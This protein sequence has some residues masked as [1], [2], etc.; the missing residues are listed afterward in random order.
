[1]KEKLKNVLKSF[2]LFLAFCYPLVFV[3]HESANLMNEFLIQ[4]LVYDIVLVILAFTFITLYKSAKSKSI[5]R[6]VFGTFL[7]IILVAFLTIG[8]LSFESRFGKIYNII[9]FVAILV[10]W[11]FSS[12]E[13]ENSVTLQSV[14]GEY[15]SPKW[16]VDFKKSISAVCKN[17]SKTIKKI[18]IALASCVV[19]VFVGIKVYAFIQSKRPVNFEVTATCSGVD[20]ENDL[21][22]TLRISFDQSACEL[23]QIEQETDKVEIKPEIKG[24]WRWESESSLYFYPSEAW[25][26]GT[27]YSI[28]L[29]KELVASHITLTEKSF[30]FKTSEF[31]ARINNLE[32]VIDDV[33][34]DLKYVVCEVNANFPFDTTSFDGKVKFQPAMLNSKNGFVENRDYS[35]TVTFSENKKTAYIRSEKIGIPATDVTMKVIVLSGVKSTVESKAL[36]EISSSIS[37]DG[38]NKFA[39]I[40]N[41]EVFIAQDENGDGTQILNFNLAGKVKTEDLAKNLKVYLLPKDRPE[42]PGT[43]GIENYD[44]SEGTVSSLVLKK[45]TRLNLERIF[46]ETEYSDVQNFKIDVPENSYI[47]IQIAKGVKFYGG[48]TLQNDYS[49]LVR[50]PPFEKKLEIV[51]KGSLLSLRGD[52]KLS[53]QTRGVK[54]LCFKIWRLKPDEINDIVTQSN[55]RFENFNFE[56]SRFDERNVGELYKEEKTIT[57]SNGFSAK[58]ATFTSF[59]F[60]KYLDTIA[61]NGIKNG[62][63]LLTAYDK[64][65]TDEVGYYDEDYVYR[66]RR[67]CSD[68]RLILVSDL[69]LIVKKTDKSQNIFVQSVKSGNPVSN[70]LV[71]LIAKNGDVLQEARTNETGYVQFQNFRNRYDDDNALNP[72]VYTVS[73][74]DDFSFMPYDSSE[75]R[76]DYSD[77][78]VSGNYDAPS[79]NVISSYIFSDRGIY[80]PGEEMRFGAITKTGSWKR[81]ISGLP[82]VYKI[83][84]PSGKIIVQKDFNIAEAGFNEFK[85]KTDSN[86]KTGSYSFRL[87]LKKKDTNGN[88]YLDEIQSESVKVEEFLPDTLEIKSNLKIGDT[89]IESKGWIKSN[90]ILSGEVNLKNLFGTPA[91]GNNVEAEITL[92]PGFTNMSKFKGYK[93]GN[94]FIG[95]ETY[96]ERFEKVATDEEGKAKFR[97]D[98]DKFKRAS[99]RLSFF[100]VGY[101][102]ESARNVKTQSQIYVSP[103]DYLIGWKADGDLSYIGKDAKRTVNFIAVNNMLEQIAASGIS[104]SLVETKFVSTLVRNPNGVYKYQSVRKDFD[105]ESKNLSIGKNGL[106]MNLP[107]SKEGEFTIVLKNADGLK[108]CEIPYSV[109][110]KKNVQ[111]SLSRTAE[112]EVKLDSSSYNAGD[113]ANLFIKAPYTGSGLICVERGRLFTYQWFSTD[114]LATEIPITIP[115]TL[116]DENETNAY[117]T[118]MFKRS[119]DSEEIFMNPFCYAAV[120][121]NVGY[122]R[123]KNPITLTVPQEAKPGKDFEISYSSQKKAKIAIF[124]VDEGVLQVAKYSKPNPFSHFFRKRALTVDCYEMLDLVMPEYEVLQ[125]VQNMS[126]A[127]GGEG[128][129]ALSK[130]INPFKRKQNEPVAYWSG[131]IDSDSETRSVKYRVPDHFNGRLH[132]F[133][134]A[135]ADSSIGVTDATSEIKADYVIVPNVPTFA[136]PNDIFEVPVTVTNTVKGSK[137]VKVTLSAELSKNLSITDKK[138][139]D[140]EIEEGKDAT[141]RFNFKALEQN[142]NADIKFIATGS[143]KTSVLKTSLSVRPSMPYQV[144]TTTGMVRKG[145]NKKDDIDVKKSLYDD[146]S[147]RQIELSYLPT[148]MASG[149][150]FYLDSYP[151]GCS[152][153]MVSRAFP[154]LYEELLADKKDPNGMIENAFAVLLNRQKSD[155]SIGYWNDRSESYPSLD[156]YCALYLTKAKEKGYSIPKSVFEKLLNRLKN[157]ASSND[158]DNYSRAFAIYV[159]TKNEIITKDYLSSLSKKLGN[160][161]KMSL[162]GMFMASSYKIMK[163]EK[164]ANSLLSKIRKNANRDD[165]KGLFEDE[166]YF[167]SLYLD[168]ICEKFPERLADISGE[169]LEKI[170]VEIEE[171]H[172]SSISS[173]FALI[174][175]EMYKKVV[176]T[177]E[178]GKFKVLE[179]FAKDL[180]KNPSEITVSG[181]DIFVGNFDKD[182]EKLTISNDEK[183]NLYYQIVHAGFLKNIPNADVKKGIEVYRKFEVDGKETNEFKVGDTVNVTISLR[184]VSDKYSN[185]AV[186]DMLPAGLEIDIESVRKAEHKFDYVDIREDR[187]VLYGKATSSANTIKYK[188]KANSCGTFVTPP[189]FAESMYDRN[190][191]ALSLTK[192]I[193]VSK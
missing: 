3:I 191:N 39:R 14:I 108:L 181:K 152:E 36:K 186:I 37:I 96:S 63:F 132:T 157:I 35:A 139:F 167:N 75:R 62:I 166:L 106:S 169:L 19:L 101:E 145:E 184:S 86:C 28:S 51:G 60:S 182:A 175:L 144:W 192:S 24:V 135:V 49:S 12:K 177:A 143:G 150:K 171:N 44:W 164:E 46:T 1:L 107:I 188:A 140:I 64:D 168:L 81:D 109:I 52:K 120:P 38:A 21:K 66:Y 67:A 70:A 112:L 183:T 80:K 83:E 23:S 118:V 22:S 16:I 82:C 53:I 138:S 15:N 173:A 103:L 42:E 159:L 148:G 130:N 84:D 116:D 117:V 6:K 34:P 71:R 115:S 68:K 123:R 125:L 100:T 55:G 54:N 156:S 7:F 105:V 85:Y 78:D 11:S 41:R 97:I 2:V 121:F 128:F 47:Y 161:E 176:P 48:Y 149:L 122:E 77:F 174:A 8:I 10:A 56:S 31:N 154:Y 137:K 13:N 187:I 32:F 79:D 4:R 5:K 111:R 193:K 26:V 127:G 146:Y 119:S 185:I 18:L 104:Y 58:K 25:K 61:V 179:K 124:A 33:D 69:G 190:V 114:T 87:F 90:E 9:S 59:D 95:D 65:S 172:Y 158:C 43:K 165:K 72:C 113:V 93:F 45:S 133:A 73:I 136:S 189:L 20:I 94:Q 27:E 126:A 147:T 155:G 102:K 134:V 30:K 141:V 89:I 50:V 180:K 142:G 88:V 76:I 162:T 151:Y 57:S 40:N 163:M 153:Q 98:L 92:K 178:T 74:L 131:I 160:S 91:I 17:N 129:D 99:Y 170:Q 110:G 29:K